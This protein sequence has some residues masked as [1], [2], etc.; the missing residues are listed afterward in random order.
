VVYKAKKTGAIMPKSK[1]SIA[2]SKEPSKTLPK[3]PKKAVAV[4]EVKEIIIHQNSRG[5]IIKLLKRFKN[6][7]Q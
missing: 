7:K 4:E 3:S 2:T 6:K 1:A 5:R